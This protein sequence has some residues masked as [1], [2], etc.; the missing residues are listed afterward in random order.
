MKNFV[1]KLVLFC[2]PLTLLQEAWVSSLSFLGS[3]Y[4]FDMLSSLCYKIYLFVLSFFSPPLGY[5]KI[6]IPFSETFCIPSNVKLQDQ[7]KNCCYKS[8]T[9][10]KLCGNRQEALYILLFFLSKECKIKH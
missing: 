7:S 5:F 1:E 9:L 8:N 10:S 2:L 3:S 6:S 4:A